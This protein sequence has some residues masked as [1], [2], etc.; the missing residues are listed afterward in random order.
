MFCV[1]VNYRTFITKKI[2]K[3]LLS[4]MT[5]GT[6][7]RF[8]GEHVEEMRHTFNICWLDQ[9]L[10]EA[11]VQGF[12]AVVTS[13]AQD[14]QKLAALL[15]RALASSLGTQILSSVCISAH[16]CS[17]NLSTFSYI[18]CLSRIHPL[19]FY[20]SPLRQVSL[21]FITAPLLILHYKEL[22]I[23]FPYIF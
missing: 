3:E 7:I 5:V 2:V 20:H 17:S 11:E 10:P 12:K 23:F 22:E 14:F 15:L 13:L 1:I 21:H 4:Y 19:S 18:S 8:S 9:K 16:T 6:C